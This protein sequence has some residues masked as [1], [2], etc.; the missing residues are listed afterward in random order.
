MALDRAQT[1]NGGD[2]A[3]V[4]AGGKGAVRAQAGGDDAARAKVAGAMPPIV[5]VDGYSFSYRTD[6]GGRR[7]V[8]DGVSLQVEEG[9]FCI[10]VGPTGCGKTTLLRSLKPELAPVGACGGSIDVLGHPVLRDGAAVSEGEGGLDRRASASAIGYVMQDPAMQIVC[11]TVWHELAFGLENLGTPQDEMR[12]RVAEVAHFFGVEPWVRQSTEDLSGGQMQTV[13]LAAVLALRPR[14]LLLDE[15]T[16]QLDPNA[17]KRFLYL[18]ARV[19][20]EL[21]ITVV[22]ATHS[23]E[24]VADYAT[25]RIDLGEVGAMG[26]REDLCRA[27]EPRWRQR[28]AVASA[29]VALE[30]RDASFRYRRDEEWVLRGLDMRVARGSVHAVVGGN[31]SGK[32][33]LLKLLA[34]IEKPQ[35]GKVRN[36][37]AADQAYMPQDPKALFVC[38]SVAEELAE[39]RGRCGYSAQDEQVALRR[40]GLAGHERQ[41]PYD[42]S[43]GQRQMLALAKLLLTDPQLLFLDEPT[44]GLDPASCAD[45]ARLVRALADEGRTV[46]LVTHDLDFALAVADEVS[47][48]FD[49]ELACTEPVDRFF[50]NNLVY[51]PNKASRLFGALL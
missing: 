45:E 1:E 40:F 16:A 13:N 46:V 5:K 49:G 27:L 2:A 23:P 25:R 37:L 34:G 22:M 51:R 47:M 50:D 17:C 24:D 12:R 20:R 7:T 28:A 38:D 8:L 36:E 3:W 33:T 10:L 44:K 9:E 31:G 39:W 42:L 6:D 21:G 18:L 32:S 30:A 26:M 19:N 14:L 29:P 11:D 4:E 43:G 15:P 48:V 35:R 41:H